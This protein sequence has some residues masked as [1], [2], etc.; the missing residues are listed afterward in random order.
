[1]I[2]LKILIDYITIASKG[3]AVDFGDLHAATT[4]VWSNAGCASPTRGIFWWS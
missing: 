1:M 2:Q 4:D 3:N